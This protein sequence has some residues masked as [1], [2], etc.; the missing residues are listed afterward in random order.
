MAITAWTY[1]A[2]DMITG[3]TKISETDNKIQSAL[4]D[5]NQW[6][7]ST[8]AY[9][10]TGLTQEFN[11]TLTTNQATFDA[12]IVTWQSEVDNIPSEKID[13][14]DID[15]AALLAR[16]NITSITYNI[17]DKPSILTYTGGWSVTATYV[18]SGNGEGEIAAIT[19]KRASDIIYVVTYTYGTND[20][21]LTQTVSDEGWTDAELHTLMMVAI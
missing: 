2:A 8:D 13:A 11:S 18:A 14:I 19:Y 5:M 6:I 9:A 4:N 17:D 16:R 12:Q 21:I 10:A 15:M 20:K 3:S 1:P 7:N